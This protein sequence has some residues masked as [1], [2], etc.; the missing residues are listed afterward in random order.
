MKTPDVKNALRA[1]FKQPEWSLFFEVADGTGLN[2]RRWADAVAVNNYPSRGLEIHGFEIKVSRGDWLSELKNPAKSSTVQQFC[3][4]WWIVAPKELIKPGEL[5][6]TW[7]HYDV[8]A[9][10]ILKQMVAA[11]KLD[12]KDINKSFMAAILR[13]ASEA[14]EAVVGAAISVERQ[15][16]EAQFSERLAREIEY[17]TT[18]AQAALDKLTEFEEKTGLSVSRYNDISEIADAIKLIR[19][20]GA[21]NSWRG[22]ESMGEEAAKFAERVKEFTTTHF[23]PKEDV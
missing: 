6:P 8:S 23:P 1:R 11:P 12:A 20:S 17:K 7:G 15:R 14:D 21:L 16:L 22:L 3:N 2:Q 9:A 19:H 18:Q 10:G 5:P 4:R 13:R